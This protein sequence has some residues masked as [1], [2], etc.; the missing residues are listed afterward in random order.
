MTL[1]SNLALAIEMTEVGAPNPGKYIVI[2]EIEGERWQLWMQLV[3]FEWLFDRN[4]RL[5]QDPIT[6]SCSVSEIFLSYMST[7]LARLSAGSPA[8]D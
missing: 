7:S 3:R 4:N 1:K 5:N 8:K 2:T 6:N